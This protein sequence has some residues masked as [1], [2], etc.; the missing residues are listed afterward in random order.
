MTGQLAGKV[1][2]ITGAGS[3]IGRASALRFAAEGARL[4]IGD[5]S[6]GVHETAAMIA[7]AGGV[8]TAMQIDAGVEADVAAMV[9]TAFSTYGGLD[10]AFANA[11]ISGGLPGIFDETPE[12]FFR[13]SPRQPARPVADGQTCR[14]GDVGSGAWGFDRLHGKRRWDPFGR[15]RARLFGVKSRRHQ[16]R[17]GLGAAAQRHRRPR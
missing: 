17:R 3:G 13:N 1:A 10:I 4:V 16:S 15:R 9:E 7:Q 11:G 12:G 5:K 2:I 6:D 14:Q 8:A